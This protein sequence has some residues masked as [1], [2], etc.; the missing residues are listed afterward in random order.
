MIPIIRYIKYLVYDIC[1]IIIIPR[2][3]ERKQKK[4]PFRI[5]AH[6]WRTIFFSFQ[7]AMTNDGGS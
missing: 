5:L 1:C 2:A 6:W 7:I 4:T 3:N